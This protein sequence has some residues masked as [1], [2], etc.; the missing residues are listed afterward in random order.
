MSVSVIGSCRK[1]MRA[2]RHFQSLG[3]FAAS[4]YE[5]A[6]PRPPEGGRENATAAC[7]ALGGAGSQYFG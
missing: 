2:R 3:E 6:A 7:R 5:S 4:R 1:D